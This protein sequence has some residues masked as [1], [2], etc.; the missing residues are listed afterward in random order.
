[1]PLSGIRAQG[2]AINFL[3]RAHSGVGGQGLGREPRAQPKLGLNLDST[4]GKSFCLSE[5]NLL[6]GRRK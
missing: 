1:M 4:L 3:A 2:R 5:P 6:S